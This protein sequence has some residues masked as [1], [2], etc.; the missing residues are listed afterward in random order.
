MNCKGPWEGYRRRARER[1]LDTRQ[2]LSATDREEGIFIQLAFVYGLRYLF[3]D[4]LS[5]IFHMM[6][7]NR[8]IAGILKQLRS[9]YTARTV[10]LL[11]SRFRGHQS[12]GMTSFD[13]GVN[14]LNTKE[15]MI[16]VWVELVD[17]IIGKAIPIKCFVSY[18]PPSCEGGSVSRAKKK[19]KEWTHDYMLNLTFNLQ[20]I[21][22]W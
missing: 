13:S 18:R 15:N 8:F 19:K 10:K 12:R 1:R 16:P 5:I 11:F 7:P 9:H 6:W 4:E 3:R 20:D 2:A 17:P 21:I 14:H 22:R